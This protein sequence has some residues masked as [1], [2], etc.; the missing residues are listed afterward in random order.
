M[1][2]QKKTIRGA[3]QVKDGG[4]VLGVFVVGDEAGAQ[5]QAVGL[6]RKPPSQNSF[7]ERDGQLAPDGAHRRVG[8]FLV[9]DKDR[10]EL[11]RL[12]A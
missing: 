1:I 6:D 4:E 11:A 8:V 5:R 9:L 10:P 2:F 12:V 7:L 3:W